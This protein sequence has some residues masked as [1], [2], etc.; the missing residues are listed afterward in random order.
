MMII[1]VMELQNGRCVSLNRGRVDD[2]ALWHVDPVETALAWASAGADWIQITDL[3]GVVGQE[4]NGD[5]IEE[6]IRVAGVP[7]QLGGG[8]R[9]RDTVER[10]VDKGAG[11]IVIGSLAVQ[12]PDLVREIAKFFPD[13]IV[14]AVDVW[15]G[16]V[17]SDGWR[18]K[19]VFTP[20]DFI[21]AFDGV[22]FSAITVTDIDADI[23][24]VDG[25]IGVISGVASGSRT[26]VFASGVIRTLDDVARLKYT[27]NIAG[28]LLGRV[29]FSK[30]IDL[31][32]AIAAAQPEP[33]ATAE[34]L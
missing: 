1:P 20:G 25:Q 34:F 31:A 30:D 11:R 24:G 29:L 14:L 9:S 2:A 15:Q 13:Q 18:S 10:W 27:P 8:F 16:Q 22:P 21:A 17:M 23:D 28:A 32:E 33:E 19:S 4:G 7:V 12:S 3:D 26:P 6:I 5:L